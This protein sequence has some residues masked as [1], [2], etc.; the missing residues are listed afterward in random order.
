MVTAGSP[1][2]PGAQGCGEG[3]VRQEETLGKPCVAW[4][5]LGVALGSL[6]ASVR[7]CGTDRAHRLTVELVKT[8]APPPR[9]G[10]RATCGEWA[11]PA[12]VFRVRVAHLS[13]GPRG[14]LRQERPDLRWWPSVR[15]PGLPGALGAFPGSWYKV[16]PAGFRLR[17][18]PLLRDWKGP[19]VRFSLLWSLVMCVRG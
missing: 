6:Q 16:H 13:E 3:R 5:S 12:Q 17:Q 4:E 19:Q 10:T 14:Y 11:G 18:T 7:T 8:Q 1:V 9:A 2:G 15:S